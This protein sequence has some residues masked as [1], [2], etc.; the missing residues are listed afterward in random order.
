MVKLKDIPEEVGDW[1]ASGHPHGWT[2]EY[3]GGE[4]GSRKV[5]L[6]VDSNDDEE[7]LSE[8]HIT[9][10][11]SGNDFK[12]RFKDG[13]PKCED[14]PDWPGDDAEESERNEWYDSGFSVDLFRWNGNRDDKNTNDFVVWAYDN[15][16]KI[17]E[18][19]K[20]FW[21]DATG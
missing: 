16:D 3:Q 15:W 6:T 7:A 8:Y 20:D 9:E 2:W 10:E 21:D 4:V 18:I 11:K 14:P 19:G 17:K 13:T 1:D 5:H 12:V